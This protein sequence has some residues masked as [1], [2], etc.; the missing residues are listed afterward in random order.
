MFLAVDGIRSGV[1]LQ[2]ELPDESLAVCAVL[3][4]GL[5]A[6]VTA[7]MDVGAGKELYNFIQYA[8]QEF[9]SLFCRAVYLLEYSPDACDVVGRV[10]IA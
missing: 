6:L 9:E 8:F 10:R 7:D 1:V 5:G 4:S 2:A 3:P